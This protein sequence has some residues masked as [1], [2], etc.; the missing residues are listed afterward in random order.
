[1]DADE[2]RLSIAVYETLTGGRPVRVADLAERTG[3]SVEHIERVLAEWPGVFRD[4]NGNVIGYWGLAIPEMPH[5]FETQG[6]RLHN[7]CAW[8]ALFIPEI[9][10]HAARYTGRCPATQ[11]EAGC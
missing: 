4:T 1:M 2:R 5:R 8:D 11:R 6:V 10:G 9:T 3:L 7:W